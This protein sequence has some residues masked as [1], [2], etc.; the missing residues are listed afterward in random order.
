M[1]Y[2]T[3]SRR[4]MLGE[5]MSILARRVR[6]PSGNSPARMRRNRSRFSAT[7]AVAVGAVLAR[8]GQG[9]P[10]LPDLLRGQVADIGLARL[11]QV[12][13]IVV[14][15]LEVVRGVIEPVLPVEAQPADVR[16]D[17]LDV[18]HFLFAGVGVVEP[19][20]ADPAELLGHAEIEADRLG[21]ADVQV[22]VGLRGKAGHD[23]AVVFAGLQVCGHDVANKVRRLSV[24]LGHSKSFQGSGE[25]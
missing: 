17:G 2:R 12:H 10:V 25:I 18:L 16:H 1:R 6:A 3:G 23:P 9:A 14:H 13:G 21:V 11:D 5:A 7:R 8:L 4:L 15:L 24:N 19:E 22:A 20:V